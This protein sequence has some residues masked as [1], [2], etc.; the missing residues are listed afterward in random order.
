MRSISITK[1]ADL[2]SP[3]LMQNCAAGRTFPKARIEF[4]RAD[5]QGERVKYYELE[6]ENVL[7][8]T[9]NQ[10]IHEGDFLQDSV[11]LKFSKV[12]LLIFFNDVKIDGVRPLAKHDNHFHVRIYCPVNDR[13]HCQDSAPYWPW[14]DGAPPGG[15][16]EELPLIRWRRANGEPL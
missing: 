16:Y 14:Y 5:G 12:P 7:I 11:S 6:L 3:V 15:H 13:S 8:G 10:S 1:L 9:V 4:L 2:A